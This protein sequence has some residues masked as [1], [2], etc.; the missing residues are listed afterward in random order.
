MGKS[1]CKLIASLFGI[2]LTLHLLYLAIGSPVCFLFSPRIG[3]IHGRR[4]TKFQLR[5]GHPPPPS[6]PPMAA[7]GNPWQ[8]M[9]AKNEFR[10]R[11]RITH[12]VSVNPQGSPFGNP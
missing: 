10:F 9:A 8:A 11:S 4:T 6:Q 3:L 12:H 1:I 5:S 2:A 7:Y